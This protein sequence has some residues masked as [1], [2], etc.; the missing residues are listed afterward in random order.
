[1]VNIEYKN[2]TIKIIL[3]VNKLQIGLLL[4]LV[5][6]SFFSKCSNFI[7]PENIVFLM[8][9]GDK[10]REHGGRNGLNNTPFL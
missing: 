7:A 1:M 9:S 5:I 3:K 8:F 4:Y 2:F 10:K 6:N